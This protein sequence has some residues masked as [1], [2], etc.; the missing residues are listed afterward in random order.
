MSVL[1]ISCT[2]YRMLSLPSHFIFI[3]L[4]GGGG[5]GHIGPGSLRLITASWHEGNHQGPHVAIKPAPI[6]SHLFGAEFGLEILPELGKDFFTT[7]V[8]LVHT[9]LPGQQ[10]SVAGVCGPIRKTDWLLQ[11]DVTES[12]PVLS[13]RAPS[14]ANCRWCSPGCWNITYH[15]C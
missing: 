9:L 2:I 14:T 11:K 1:A 13:Q 3:W 6:L 15:C 7:F 12:A 8:W 4:A 5:C 10:P